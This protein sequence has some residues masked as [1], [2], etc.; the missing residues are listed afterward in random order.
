[1]IEQLQDGAV[2]RMTLGRIG[3]EVSQNNE[4]RV[5]RWQTTALPLI[6]NKK[7]CAVQVLDPEPD[8]VMIATP[9][10]LFWPVEGWWCGMAEQQVKGTEVGYFD[11]GIHVVF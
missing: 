3:V 11:Y 6:I 4:S 10:S 9:V 5:L 8:F 1:M 2:L 7:I